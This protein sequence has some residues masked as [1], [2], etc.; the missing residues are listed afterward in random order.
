MTDVSEVRR[1]ADAMIAMIKEDQGTGQISA[2]V[3]SLD[4]LDNYVDIEDFYRRIRLTAV[5]HDAAEL[6][7]WHS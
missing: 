3:S 2:D 4:E 1:H 5:D 7:P 6:R